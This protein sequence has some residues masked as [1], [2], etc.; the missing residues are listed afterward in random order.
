MDKLGQK[1]SARDMVLSKYIKDRFYY[2]KK[3]DLNFE[4]L[5]LE[6]S[7]DFSK[8]VD[9]Y[10][11]NHDLFSNEWTDKFKLGNMFQEMSNRGVVFKSSKN[12]REKNYF[13]T[14][15]NPA[16]PLVAKRDRVKIRIDI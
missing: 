13:S 7:I 2:K 1:I 3:L 14:L 10:I 4:P 15:V 5:E 12:R 11:K 16:I 9:S 6:G 8:S